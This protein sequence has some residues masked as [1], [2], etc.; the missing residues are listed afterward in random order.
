MGVFDRRHL[1]TIHVDETNQLGARVLASS[2][3]LK[4]LNCMRAL[5]AELGRLDTN[6]AG[7]TDVNQFK[8]MTCPS[9]SVSSDALRFLLLR[10]MG[11]DRLEP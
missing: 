2:L 8:P 4:G 11:I 3:Q 5:P 7:H 9:I 1:H 10:Y 6:Q